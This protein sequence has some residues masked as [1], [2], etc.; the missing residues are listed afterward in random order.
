MPTLNR[1]NA[2][3]RLPSGVIEG[4]FFRSGRV[5][6]LLPDSPSPISPTT[7]VSPRKASRY[8]HRRLQS[9]GSPRFGLYQEVVSAKESNS[10]TTALE[11]IAPA[12]AQEG[13]PSS[14]RHASSGSM[15][16]EP[17][18]SRSSL[19]S[20]AR[21]LFTAPNLRISG[22]ATK[23]GA[24]PR[25]PRF[26]YAWKH[27]KSGHWLEIRAGRMRRSEGHA[28]SDSETDASTLVARPQA[29]VTDK[30]PATQSPEVTVN[31]VFSQ[32]TPKITFQDLPSP[33]ARP[34]DGLY[35]R[36]KR[37]LGL[38]RCVSD[39]SSSTEALTRTKTAEVLERT[40]S[41]LRLVAPRH[42][43]TSPSTSSS[44]LSSLSIAAPRRQLFR[45]GHAR[46]GSSSS[47][48]RSLLMG[49]APVSTPEPQEMY[50][51]TDNKQYF[52]VEMTDPGAP[53]FL[54]SEARRINTPPIG[55]H[56]PRGFFF[57]YTA[58]PSEDPSPLPERSAMSPTS[59]D[60]QTMSDKQ[61]R[62]SDTEWYKVKLDAIE[63]DSIAREQ[64]ALQ[65]PDHLPNSPL[66]PRHPK[67]KS[68]GTGVCPMHG[69]NNALS[70]QSTPLVSPRNLKSDG[71]P[72]SPKY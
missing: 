54:P 43:P 66:C 41:A 28:R 23:D 5:N 53:T 14:V 22:N 29:S 47:S 60:S 16:S 65:V 4:A 30:S 70:E 61:R 71:S 9:E 38:K 55:S 15:E 25:A 7:F 45:S 48:V 34:Q 32:T 31:N 67:H 8:G 21:K 1:P 40:A 11:S 64:F 13:N 6:Q 58:P 72:H 35:A 44:G 49:K 57:D 51:G 36:T 18:S 46:V 19:S 62:I 33:R 26:G 56:K 63:A 20:K 2:P 68:G 69:R 52:N 27:E 17:T 12:T 3:E 50:T 39:S 59:V 24:P 37:R 42:S 10:T